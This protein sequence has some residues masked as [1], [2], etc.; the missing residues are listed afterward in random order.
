M[1]IRKAFMKAIIIKQ[2]VKK[3]HFLFRYFARGFE[4]ALILDALN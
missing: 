1:A 3:R 4:K 2:D